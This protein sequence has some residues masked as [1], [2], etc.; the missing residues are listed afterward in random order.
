MNKRTR[1]L[2]YFSAFAILVFA[3]KKKPIDAPI[4][5]AA[6]EYTYKMAG[7]FVWHGTITTN[8]IV[9]SMTDVVT[10]FVH[11]DTS[12][13][14]TIP[15]KMPL[16]VNLFN[17]TDYNDSELV[18]TNNGSGRV[19]TFNFVKGLLTD[20]Y[21][22][23]S[24]VVELHTAVPHQNEKWQNI[25][26]PKLYEN[27]KWR[28][29]RKYYEMSIGAYT[30]ITEEV[31]GNAARIYDTLFGECAFQAADSVLMMYR[32]TSNNY[33]SVY[34]KELLCYYPLTDS[35]HI[36]NYEQYLNDTT[37]YDTID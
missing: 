32:G 24:T 16:Y 11:N 19:I 15:Y 27:R 21:S 31:M 33:G 22:Y 34:T 37:T 18:F 20:Q 28:Y 1:S 3:C 36:F 5:R 9:Q 8:G 35:I 30:T 29:S 26:M 25:W 7:T 17:L 14:F 12:I 2:L 23:P 10:I 6:T 4:K 13:Y